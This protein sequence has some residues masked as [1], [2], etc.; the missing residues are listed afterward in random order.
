MTAP[1]TILASAT[2]SFDYQVGNPHFQGRTIVHITGDG[3]AEASF[4]RG[5][6]VDSYKGPVPA[7]K[8][9]ALRESL[10]RHPLASY[11]PKMRPAV[12]DEVTMEFTLVSGG[13]RSEAKILDNERHEIDAL[14]E[15]VEV[16]QDIAKKVSGGKIE[17]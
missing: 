7:A 5:G 3:N 17:Y 13:E 11:K 1:A 9:A 10:T 14:G 16:I 6:K 15:L 4:E 2:D 12:P 8:L